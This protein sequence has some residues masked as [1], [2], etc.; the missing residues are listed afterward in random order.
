MQ[1][2]VARP[3]GVQPNRQNSLMPPRHTYWTI[4]LEGK[5]TAFRARRAG[6]TAADAEAA[7]GASSRRG[8]DVVCARPAVEIAGRGA[9]RR[10]VQKRPPGERR[11]R[12][13]RPGGAHE[14]RASVSRSRATRSDGASASGCSATTR[15]RPGN[16][17]REASRGDAADDA[18]APPQSSPSRPPDREGSTSAAGGRSTRAAALGWKATSEADRTWRA[19]RQRRSWMETSRPPGKARRR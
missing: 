16:A 13:W 7:A 18:D 8:D 6:R 19:S 15:R 4:I 17:G 14:I 9:A 3:T 2:Q 1:L 10:S 5:P 12:D 11:G